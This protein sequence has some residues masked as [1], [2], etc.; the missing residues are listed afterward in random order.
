M[1]VA[2]RDRYDLKI[3]NADRAAASGYDAYVREF[4]SYGAQLRALFAVAEANP[5]APL[6]NAHAAALHLAFEGAEGWRNAEP[7]LERMRENLVGAS[8]REK[9]FCGAVEA[10]SRKDFYAAL[11]ALDDLTVRWP[12]DLC[13][14]KWGQYHAFNLGDQQALLRFG[15]RARIVHEGTPYVH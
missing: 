10:W 3:S 14:I 9:H 15:E 8:L 13:A 7:Y 5:H 12:A 6:L 2:A 11:N 4:L 1:S